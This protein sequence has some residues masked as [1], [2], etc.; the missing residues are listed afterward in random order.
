L[1]L[2]LFTI[3]APV[4][5]VATAGYFWVRWDLPF[6]SAFI[7]RIVSYLGA[8]CLSFSALVTSKVALSELAHVA[9]GMV[10]C[11]LLA[12]AVG[13]LMLRI[14]GWPSRI[15]LLPLM[16]PNLGNIGL[17]VCYYAFGDAGLTFGVASLAATSV[18]LWTFGMWIA[19]GRLSIKQLAMQPALIAISAA[20]VCLLADISPPAW[21]LNTTQ[22]L[23]GLAIPLLL[24]TLGASLARLKIID[25]RRSV[26][27]G[28]T[29]IAVGLLLA[30]M[31][32]A[33]LGLGGAARGVL[34]LQASMPS[35]VFA[36]LFAQLF[37]NE[38]EGVAGIIV[39]ST[40]VGIVT[41]PLVVA[42]V[43]AT[44]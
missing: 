2:Q 37:N 16:F 22:L 20:I 43:L 13:V 14:A 38:P 3:L 39:A 6:D 28:A 30:V 11:I 33:L 42:W 12:G 31:I 7:T 21:I 15:Y 23:G 35:A 4:F 19:A 24:I 18:V 25:L 8:P 17:P 9:S 36:V 34:I 40:L 10:F 44:T 1:L 32:S 5:I 26:L 27:L 41:V 29:R